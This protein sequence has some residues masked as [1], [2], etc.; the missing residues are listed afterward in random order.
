MSQLLGRCPYFYSKRK[1]NA[2]RMRPL[3][4][5][6]ASCQEHLPQV[7]A[8]VAVLDKTSCL[9]T[10]FAPSAMCPSAIVRPAGLVAFENK[11]YAVLRGGCWGGHAPL[12]A[13]RRLGVKVG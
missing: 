6:V 4:E 10:R 5:C 12:K 1:E 13:D 9:R 7:S 2:T 8:E 3:Q 11:S